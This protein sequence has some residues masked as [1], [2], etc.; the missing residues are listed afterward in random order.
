L[1]DS[2]ALGAVSC[3]RVLRGASSRFFAPERARRCGTRPSKYD[4]TTRCTLLHTSAESMA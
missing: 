3:I 1:S 2:A 4:G